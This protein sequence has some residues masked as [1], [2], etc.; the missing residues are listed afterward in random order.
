MSFTACQM[1]N[2]NKWK[3]LHDKK[4]DHEKLNWIPNQFAYV[5]VQIITQFAILT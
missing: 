5:S 3:N 1:R 2:H 4:L